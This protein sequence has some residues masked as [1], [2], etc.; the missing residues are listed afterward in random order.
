M[1]TLSEELKHAVRKGVEA[2]ILGHPDNPH[3]RND[4]KHGAWATGYAEG[5]RGVERL[6]IT[7]TQHA[8]ARLEQD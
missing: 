8:I 6:V 7:A 2:G 3:R 5:I 4:P 1:P